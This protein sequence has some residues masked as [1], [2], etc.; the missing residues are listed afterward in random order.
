MSYRETLPRRITVQLD[1]IDR[2]GNITPLLKAQPGS[3][4]YLLFTQLP[5]R[6]LSGNRA[7]KATRRAARTP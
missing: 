4:F 5:L 3:S 7:R 6:G 2:A 1:H